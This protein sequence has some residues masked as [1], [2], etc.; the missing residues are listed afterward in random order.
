[1]SEDKNKNKPEKKE[2]KIEFK[3]VKKKNNKFFFQNQFHRIERNVLIT[4]C[5]L[6]GGLRLN[7]H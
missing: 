5:C 4:S 7:E 1:M 2:N 3:I 6:N